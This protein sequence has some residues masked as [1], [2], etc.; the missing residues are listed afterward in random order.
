[1][2]MWYSKLL[3]VCTLLV[4][5][6]RL[7]L[8]KPLPEWGQ[9]HFLNNYEEEAEQV[10][11]SLTGRMKEDLIQNLNLSGVSIQEKPMMKLPQYMIDLYNQYAD[12]RT[13]MPMANVIRSFNAEDIMLSSS[14]E[15]PIQS[16]ILLF[17]VTIPWHEEI[18]KAELKMKISLGDWH[19][20]HL[21]L[22]DVIHIE[23]SENLK[24][25]NSFLASK[26]V[27]EGESVTIDI[28]KAVKRWIKSKVEKNK[29]EIF[30]KAK[31][32]QDAC[33]K[34]TNIDI[35][36]DSSHPPILIIFSDDQDNKVKET[37]M[38]LNQMI[39]HEQEKNI[40]IFL[41]NSTVEH[42][43]EHRE[44]LVIGKTLA[45]SKKRVKRTAGRNY[46]K[47]TSL[48]VN[49]KDIGWDSVII[50]PPNYDA[51][52]CIGQCYFPLTDNLTPTK[53]AIIQT[54]M[55]KQRPKDVEKACCVPTKLEAIH[56]VYFD[57]GVPTINRNY[58]EMKVVECGC[59]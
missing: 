37:K 13:S 48:I 38:E 43:E 20:G 2:T 39:L 10:L 25:P 16:H 15:N 1:M 12:D 26:D 51:G 3:V 22:F 18:T 28:T 4:F 53:H 40:G 23:L 52:Q 5:L 54:L 57:N 7:T 8:T 6:A 47:K 24:D 59:R 36:S 46:C 58:E 31:I 17:N 35:S 27:E 30:L 42:V 14:Q 34:T 9:K 29:L 56:V 41:Q 33:K 21:S 44:H 50:F 32:P 55:N 19:L 11:S 49:F 45:K